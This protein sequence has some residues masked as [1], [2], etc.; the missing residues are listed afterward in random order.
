MGE[1]IQILIVGADKIGTHL[2]TVFKNIPNVD[3]VGIVDK[4]PDAMGLTLARKEGIPTGMSCKSFCKTGNIDIILNVSN[5]PELPEYFTKYK[6]YHT[7]IVNGTSVSL[8]GILLQEYKNKEHIEQKY[9][10]VK[11]KLE[12]VK[13]E[14]LKVFV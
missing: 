1:K 5:N 8:M 4:N 12:S 11:Q 2:L 14:L 6:P 13:K 7:E 10:I 3:I 9:N